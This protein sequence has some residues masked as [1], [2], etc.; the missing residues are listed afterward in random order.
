[1]QIEPTMTLSRTA[2]IEAVKNRRDAVVAEKAQERLVA[3]EKIAAAA[4]Y[5]AALIEWHAE[6][7]DGLT[8][9][10]YS[11][12]ANGSVVAAKGGS[13]PSDQPQFVDGRY[14]SVELI[15]ADEMRDLD[16]LDTALVLLEA[17]D[18]VDVTVDAGDY[19]RLLKGRIGYH[20]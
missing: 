13:E 8:N 5:P 11:L 12:R 20:Y 9:G 4:A 18:D 1:M 7:A 19:E 17:A 15:D 10:Q 14:P 3:S 6:I 16:W 2:M